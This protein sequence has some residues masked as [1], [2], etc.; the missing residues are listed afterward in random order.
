MKQV[1]YIIVG[2][3]LAGS[4]LIQT[5]LH[6][7]QTVK[8][9]ASATKKPSS[10]IAAGLYNPVTG[11][12]MLLTWNAK[13]LFPL[14]EEFYKKVEK[15][16]QT[17][18]IYPKKIY[19][20]FADIQSQN[21]FWIKP[22]DEIKAF[23]EPE[24]DSKQ[25]EPYINNPFGG[26]STKQSGYV[27][28]KAFLDVIKQ[29]LLATDSYT[30]ETFDYNALTFDNNKVQYKDTEA[31]RIIFAE[32][33]HNTNNPFFNWVPVKGMKGDVLT[34]KIEDYPINDV[35]NKHFF[36][37]PLPNGTYR[38][39]SS[40][41]NNFEDDL[42]TE[43]GLKEITAGAHTILKKPFVVLEQKAGIRPTIAD[44]R[45][46]IGEHPEQ[47]LVLIFNGL[48]TKGVS[49]APYAAIELTKFLVLGQEI[50]ESISVNRFYYL[51]SNQKSSQ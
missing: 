10:E 7:K 23:A 25:Y 22:S 48:G 31:K 15:E 43:A 50:K 11:K 49:I 20:P 45:P 4:C 27:D 41:I 47:P 28:V 44:H 26:L 21:D 6:E 40:Y 51:Y 29:Q 19:R 8:V 3:G 30:A 35:V 46:I 14:L 17:R 42:P 38:M 2:Q 32:G 9:I 39:G 13:I 33:Y 16:F 1:D 36:I 12:K 24:Q 18:I 34:L 37:I 5:L